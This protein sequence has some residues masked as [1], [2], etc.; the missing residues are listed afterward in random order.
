MSVHRQ[1]CG[2][3][4][5]E[6]TNWSRDEC[7]DPAVERLSGG[8]ELVDGGVDAAQLAGTL[9]DLT[10]INRFLG[11]AEL[12]WR[13]VRLLIAGRATHPVSLLDVGT[14][15]ADIPRHVLRRASAAGVPLRVTAT[16]PRPEVVELAR[17]WSAP[18]PDLAIDV[19]PAD[20]LPFAAA[21][22]DIAH[23]SL[24]MHHLEPPA[25][26]ALLG[27]MGRVAREG[28]IVNDLVRARR[29]WIG[30]LVMS[31]VMTR[32]TYTRHDA[33]LSVR[34][35]YLASELR[36]LAGQ[37]GLRQAGLLHDRLGHRFA[38]LLKPA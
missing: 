4:R 26:I 32:N 3:Q 2:R 9:R 31:R 10:R 38:M 12:S 25:A 35:A 29:W 18:T 28:V 36:D 37:A 14:G 33:P 7:Y 34:R 23:A 11:G 19:A 5:H 30:A 24:V 22:F 16:D 27:E 15:A 17:R 6:V 8:R 1:P 20:R 13:V 21:T